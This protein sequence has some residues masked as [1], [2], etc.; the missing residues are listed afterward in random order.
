MKPRN[1]ITMSSAIFEMA[2]PD[3]WI[4]EKSDQIF[5]WSRMKSR[6]QKTMSVAI[7]KPRWRLPISEKLT[8]TSELLSQKHWFP[9]SGCHPGPRNTYII[10]WYLIVFFRLPAIGSRHLE[11]RIGA[12]YWFLAGLGHLTE[13][14]NVEMSNDESRLLER[15][16]TVW[17]KLHSA[18]IG[19]QKTAECQMVFCYF[20]YQQYHLIQEIYSR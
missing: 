5:F 1:R 15:L 14:R 8:K 6:N 20:V 16:L 12:E 4:T 18:K 3:F 7:C 11:F 9:D 10:F 17:Q 13:C 2:T 19:L